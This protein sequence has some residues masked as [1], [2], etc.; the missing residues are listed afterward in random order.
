MIKQIK[1]REQFAYTIGCSASRPLH[2]AVRSNLISQLPKSCYGLMPGSGDNYY[3]CNISLR[4]IATIQQIRMLIIITKSR[5][6]TAGT[7]LLEYIFL[8]DTVRPKHCEQ[9]FHKRM[10]DNYI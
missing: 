1:A 7:I 9:L 6:S 10:N 4:M 3:S 8:P 5:E 2:V